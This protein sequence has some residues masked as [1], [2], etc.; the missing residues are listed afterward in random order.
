MESW[1]K[2]SLSRGSS[3]LPVNSSETS[4]QTLSLVV[5]P[6]LPDFPANGGLANEFSLSIN[7]FL[8]FKLHPQMTVT[9]EM[10]RY[11]FKERESFKL[12]SEETLALSEDEKL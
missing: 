11:I 9:A 10:R 1:T 4:H 5:L 6:E 7:Y 8:H 12:K 3:S 2:A